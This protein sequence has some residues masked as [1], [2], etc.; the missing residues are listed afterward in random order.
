MFDDRIYEIIEKHPNLNFFNQILDRSIFVISPNAEQ[1]LNDSNMLALS[2]NSLISHQLIIDLL[3][4]AYSYNLLQK[5]FDGTLFGINIFFLGEDGNYIKQYLLRK[6]N[7]GEVL[8][9]ID[10]NKYPTL[11]SKYQNLLYKL[12]LASYIEEHKDDVYEISIDNISYKIKVADIFE[13]IMQDEESLA[14]VLD[15]KPTKLFKIPASHFLYAVNIYF[16]NNDL[17]RTYHT[18]TKVQNSLKLISLSKKVDIQS[19]NKY[20]ET[21]DYMLPKVHVDKSLEMA[22]LEYLPS[23][24]NDLEK[25]IYIY[26]MMCK[27]LTYDETFYAVNQKGPLAQAHKQIENIITITLTNNRVVCY[28]FNAMYAYF[29]N[30]LG[31]NYKHFVMVTNS[32]GKP[33]VEEFFEGCNVYGEGHTFLRFRFGKFL[34]NADSVKTILQGDIMQAKLNQPLSGLFC[35]NTNEQTKKEFQ[36]ALQ[37]VYNY[38]AKI[39]PNVLNTSPNSQDQFQ[40]ILAT[41]NASTDKFRQIPLQERISI[42]IQKVNESILGGIDA[43]SYLLQL[44]KI[45]FTE[46]E[47][48]E[49]VN[50]TLLR[51]TSLTND[52][53]TISLIAVISLKIN[54]NYPMI[55]RFV[56]KP[57]QELIS[58]TEEELKTKFSSDEFAYVDNDS[59][60]IPA[61]KR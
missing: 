59:P 9:R 18:P 31:I 49:N 15:A 8:K 11:V 60:K 21:K 4:N 10:I 54:D 45:L 1:Y 42:L 6:Q 53:P 27:V 12:S 48:R 22:I 55:L 36:E 19:I 43:Y 56:Y 3:S 46:Q 47:R 32:F 26:I 52:G 61:L 23:E 57:G 28:E 25:A 13:F 30:G 24:F 51:N 58:I 17:L 16:L 37:K 7:F 50:I 14:A 44:S 29:L 38:I 5:L 39:T 41:F 33:C 35:L 2:Y 40:S 34:I 20:L